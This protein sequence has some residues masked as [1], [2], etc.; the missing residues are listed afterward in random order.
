MTLTSLKTIG[1]SEV[2]LYLPHLTLNM[3][4]LD[5]NY[6]NKIQH[7]TRTLM[8]NF[9]QLRVADPDLGIT[10]QSIQDEYEKFLDEKRYDILHPTITY[11]SLGTSFIV[12]V[13]VIFAI[14]TCI[15]RKVHK[16]QQFIPDQELETILQ[17]HIPDTIDL[18]ENDENKL[19]RPQ[20]ATRTI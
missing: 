3:K 14:V 1:T 8:N 6:Y 5:E 15:K 10:F 12:L 7:V 4:D 20:A 19:N 2:L 16:K 13:L 18:E 11:N 17:H 9:N